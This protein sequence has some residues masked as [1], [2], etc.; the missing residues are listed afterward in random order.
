MFGEQWI[1]SIEI[2]K[3]FS[4]SIGFQLV[5]SAVGSI[6]Q[7]TNNLKLMFYAGL[8]SLAI[9]LVAIIVGVN[10]L[11]MR[12]LAINI[13]IA[14]CLIFIIYHIF[15]I[16]FALKRKLLPFFKIIIYPLAFSLLLGL[17]Y[18]IA[19]NHLSYY[20]IIFSL[21]IKIMIFITLMIPISIIA[22]Y[23]LR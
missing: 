21:L 2:F 6:F 13:L 15:L 5:Q 16:K 19:I 9:M 18:K 7:A 23:K 14:F 22:K 11:V 17:I 20:N 4:L 8:I 12:S 10:T 3:I 1:N